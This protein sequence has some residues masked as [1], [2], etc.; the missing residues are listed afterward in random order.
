MGRSPNWEQSKVIGQQEYY[1]KSHRGHHDPLTQPTDYELGL[2]LEL[3]ETMA[4]FTW[5]TDVNHYK[6]IFFPNFSLFN[7]IHLYLFVSLFNT[8]FFSLGSFVTDEGSW[9]ETSQVH[10]LCYDK[11]CS[12]MSTIAILKPSLHGLSKPSNICKVKSLLLRAK[13]KWIVFFWLGTP[14]SFGVIHM[15]DASRPP[16][17]FLHTASDHNG[18]VWEWG[19]FFTY[20]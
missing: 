7:Y 8:G 5:Q 9:A 10:R 14:P 15:I 4:C 18:K 20:S 16:L 3:E 13:N 6:F 11:V 12:L 17:P 1:W 2:W 19:W